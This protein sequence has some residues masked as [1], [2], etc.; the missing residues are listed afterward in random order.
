VV[1]VGLAA[2]LIG[3]AKEIFFYALIE[4]VTAADITPGR[5]APVEFSLPQRST[6]AVPG[7]KDSVI[8]HIDDI[9]CGQLLV[10]L[11]SAD[12]ALLQAPTQS[13]AR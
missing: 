13:L 1:F 12:D 3:T 9:T 2:P 4:H 10:S 6:I 5:L 7:T 11:T 8:L